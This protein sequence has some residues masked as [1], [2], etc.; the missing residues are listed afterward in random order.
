M[1]QQLG[2]FDIIEQIDPGGYTVVYRAKQ[3]MGHGVS[4]PAAIKIL[5]GWKA[6]D[7]E[8]IAALR[9]EVSVLADLSACPNIVTIYG[10]DI[11]PEVGPWIAMEL[12]GR[13]ARHSTLEE[14]QDPAV[15]RQLLRDILRA[16]T[17]LHGAKPPVLHR[18]LKPN[19]ILSTDIGTWKLADFGLAKRSDTESTLNVLS[20]QYAAPEL[21]DTTL[22]KEGPWTDLY[23]L[24]LVAYEMALGRKLYKAQFPSVYDPYAGP[25]ATRVDE[26]PKWMYWHTTPHLTLKPLAEVLPG[27]PKD[28]SDLVAAML[29]K[30]VGE[31]L[32]SAHE[33][34]AR[35]RETNEQPP[36]KAASMGGGRDDVK[37]K[38]GSNV[39][40]IAA[41][42]LGIAAV[43]LIGAWL[44]LQLSSRPILTLADKSGRFKTETGVVQV[45]GRIRNMPNRA[46]AA[47][48]T[49]DGTRIPV[50][51]A[52]DGKFTTDVRLSKLGETT[53]RLRLTE[54]A[55]RL[56]EQPVVLER[57]APKS[58]RIVVTTNPPTPDVEVQL[59][60]GNAEASPIVVRTD[61]KGVAEAPVAFG[62]FEIRLNH[63][64]FAPA[65]RLYETGLD[66]PKTIA[67]NLQALAD[68]ALAEA[69]RNLLLAAD[70]AASD[71]LSGGADWLPALERAQRDLSL[72]EGRVDDSEARRRVSLVTEM[73]DVA[74]R[75]QGG[76]DRAKSRLESLRSEVQETARSVMADRGSD[77][78]QALM[79]DIEDAVDRA[80][81]GETTAVDRIAQVR[82]E[83]GELDAIEGAG[84]GEAAQRAR[85]MNEMRELAG[86]A[87]RGESIAGA[88]LRDSL[89]QLQSMPVPVLSGGPS[90]R[91]KAMMEELSVLSR[92]AAGGE[93]QAVEGMRRVRENI[94]E[95]DKGERVS[96]PLASRRARLLGDIINLADR[97]SRGD[98]QSAMRL[99]QV[100]QELIGLDSTGAGTSL[101]SRD[102]A[103]LDRRAALVRELA[104][105][106]PRVARDPKSAERLR[107]VRAELQAIEVAESSSAAGGAAGRRRI[108]LLT[109]LAEITEMA[110]GGDATA[111]ARVTLIQRELAIL[112]AVEQAVG[113]PDKFAEAASAMMG[114]VPSLG[115]IDRGTLLQLPDEQFLSFIQ[116]V[117]PVGALDIEI[118]PNLRRLR[119]SGTV[120]TEREM[121][122][123]NTR[124]EPAAPRLMME[125]RADAWVLSRRMTEAFR[126]AG[127]SNVRVHPYLK[128]GDDALFVQFE[129]DNDEA[130]DRA[131][132]LASTFV[133]DHN[134]LVVQPIPKGSTPPRRPAEPRAERISH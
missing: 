8:Q 54:G 97:A 60:Q 75:A 107:Q 19:N 118:V 120:M 42:V 95:L 31:R 78:R 34:L 24:G 48:V 131:H 50:A 87:S 125:V 113:D 46:V 76:D 88:S 6:D 47:I 92:K 129:S 115:L 49:S 132:S 57:V 102:V 22:G 29:V 41:G 109:E 26:R 37:G 77:R 79:R 1:K 67:A 86:R 111:S 116:A 98:V 32:Q 101:V 7:P 74:K 4:R 55:T 85:L 121:N 2:N 27:F 106:A 64:R 100:E 36:T 30:P 96:A 3:Q 89:R 11:D 69:R 63:P 25:D 103:S 5:Q 18:D 61:S 82:G 127:F 33:A 91:R 66:S 16:L 20:V 112:V 84:V 38:K 71:A 130:R 45:S 110:V 56:L 105:I 108:E 23:S 10:F 28:I 94:V 90:N 70:R 9:R 124:L 39:V 35:L 126:K 14:P 80:L 122:L 12:G 68:T 53:A 128:P 119:V 15:V 17:A 65:S 58:V 93:A 123:L 83:I 59:V 44:Y 117:V 13:S 52:L 104:D 99:R 133:I 51:P 73:I 134:L 81:K 40:T 114:T 72:L 21:L 62:K 43:L